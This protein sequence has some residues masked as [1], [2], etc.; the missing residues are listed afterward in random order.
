MEVDSHLHSQLTSVDLGYP[1][2]VKTNRVYRLLI[3]FYMKTFNMTNPHILT[4]RPSNQAVN[5]RLTVH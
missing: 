3:S 2:K 1:S 5:E 4:T